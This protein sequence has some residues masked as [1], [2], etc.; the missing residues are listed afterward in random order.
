MPYTPDEILKA[1]EQLY[2]QLDE[3]FDDIYAKCVLDDQRTTL[4]SLFVAARDAY[5]KAVKE[6]LCDNNATV[7]KITHDLVDTNKTIGA[8]VQDLKDIV[9]FIKLCSTAVQL[10]ASLATLAAAA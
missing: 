2:E 4:R 9:A 8:Q 1:I 6:T 3:N 10:A 7:E 5:F